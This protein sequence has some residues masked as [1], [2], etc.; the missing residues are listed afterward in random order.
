MNG[1]LY[2][3]STYGSG[4]RFIIEFSLPIKTESTA[5][6]IEHI[7][8]DDLFKSNQSSAYKVLLVED[9]DANILVASALLE[10]HGYT[11]EVAKNGKDALTKIYNNRYDLVLMDVQMP[12]ING[13]EVTKHVREHEKKAGLDP[14]FIIGMTAFAFA[15]DKKRCFDSGM[16]DYLAKP[17]DP[18]NFSE[19]L[20][21]YTFGKKKNLVANESNYLS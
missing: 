11:Y 14:T 10:Y 13:F 18:K 5:L 16:D 4:S 2:V 17:F 6:K 19:K 7:A 3:E 20:V 1:K 12:E 15:D 21:K 8:D 9:N